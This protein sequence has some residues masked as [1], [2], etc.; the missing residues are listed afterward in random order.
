M[1]LLVTRPE[2]DNARTAATLRAKGHEVLLAPML[3]I[4]SIPDADLGS[5][6]WSGVL[7]TSANGA[8]ALAAHPRCGELRSLPVLAVGRASADV[9]RAAGF[10]DVTSADGDADDLVRLTAMRF[11]PSRVRLLYPAGEDRSRDLAGALSMKGIG[12]HTVV[13]YRAVTANDFPPEVQAAL[14]QG[15]IDGVLHFSRRSVDGYLACSR[16]MQR[17]ALKPMH[18]CLS[19]RAA[20]PLRLAG[21]TRIAVSAHPDEASLIAEISQ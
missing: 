17:E 4:E 6:P 20:E 15:R 14:A 3:R 2:P 5:P 12:V 21:A 9:A 8:R 7:L 10:A 19:D 16:M 13:A 18:Y 1:R 11:A